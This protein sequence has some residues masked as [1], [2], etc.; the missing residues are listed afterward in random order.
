MTYVCYL[1]FLRR[2]DGIKCNVH[3]GDLLPLQPLGFVDHLILPDV[4]REVP[5]HHLPT[6]TPRPVG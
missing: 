4:K 1:I 2:D 6:H 3:F 5:T